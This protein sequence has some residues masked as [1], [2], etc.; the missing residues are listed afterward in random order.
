MN[1]YGAAATFAAAAA[2]VVPFTLATK[3][4]IEFKHFGSR[5]GA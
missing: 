1:R 5:F 3:L 4:V 2:L